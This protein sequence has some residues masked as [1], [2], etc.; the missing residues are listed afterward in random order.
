MGHVLPELVSARCTIY[1]KPGPTGQ[2]RGKPMGARARMG[3]S[4]QDG[5]TDQGQMEEWMDRWMGRQ[6]G[7]DWMGEWIDRCTN[8]G[9]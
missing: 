2:G 7:G 8:G 3:A 4:S 6:T 1:T 5:Q 9:G